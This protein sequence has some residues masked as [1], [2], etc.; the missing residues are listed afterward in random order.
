MDK[1]QLCGSCDLGSIPGG[2]T[3]TNSVPRAERA[4]Q[5]DSCSK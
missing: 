2:G 4:N 1:I 5:S 3:K